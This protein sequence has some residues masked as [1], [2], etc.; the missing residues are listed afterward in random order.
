MA[1]GIPALSIGNHP[2]NHSFTVR[3]LLCI[4]CPRHHLHRSRC[5]VYV[6]RVSR[7]FKRW[8]VR[9]VTSSPHFP[10]SNGRAEAAAAVKSMKKIIRRTWDAQQRHLNKKAWTRA[11]VQYRNTPGVT[12]LSP[13]QQLFGHPLQDLVPAHRRSFAPEWQQQADAAERRQEATQERLEARYNRTA[14]AL[15]VLEVGTRVAVQ[16]S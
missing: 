11:L 15:P 2:P 7:F 1:V 5:T 6:K 13:A 4:R 9:H 16:D 3:H 10:Q 14:R 8:G 12:G